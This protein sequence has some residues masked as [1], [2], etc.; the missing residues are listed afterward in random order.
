MTISIN[1]TNGPVQTISTTISTPSLKQGGL[2]PY[3]R[4]GDQEGKQ[5][6]TLH[7]I[8][9]PIP[10]DATTVSPIYYLKSE[11][12]NRQDNLSNPYAIQQSHPIATELQNNAEADNR[13]LYPVIAESDSGDDGIKLSKIA[14]GLCRFAGKYLDLTISEL[15][16]WYSGNRSIHIHTGEL[17]TSKGW[18]RLQELTKEFNQSN[19]SDV[20]IDTG[21]YSRK[22][23][24]RIPGVK[25]EKTRGRKVEI[26][27]TWSHNKIFKQSQASHRTVPRTYRDMLTE[28][29]PQSVGE[30]RVNQDIEQPNS[31]SET[32]TDKVLSSR[33]RYTG[34]LARAYD[35]PPISPYANADS[36]G[37]HS[38]TIVHVLDKPFERDGHN[39]VPCLVYGAIGGGGD[40]RVFGEDEFYVRRPVKLSAH[41]I[42]KWDYEFSDRVVILG[43]KSRRSRI[44]T[45]NR[46][47]AT[48]LKH[49]LQDK[50]RKSAIN[51]LNERGYET[52]KTGMNGSLQNQPSEDSARNTEAARLKR[53]IEQEGLG[54]VENEYKTI[55]R[56][57]CRLLRIGGWDEAWTWI[58]EVYGDNFDP[59]QTH[60][61]L[62]KIVRS[63][64]EYDESI[65]PPS[66]TT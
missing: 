61:K 20:E 17:V 10:D 11:E 49:I 16:L 60:Q 54:A 41:D 19:S 37:L 14:N 28:V 3:V 65:I 40:Y 53:Q 2:I 59:E 23:Q 55:L 46:H 47:E 8:D 57:S 39:Y 13:V 7:S 66:P 9:E 33:D 35:G 30:L 27:Q 29:V 12:I 4:Y 42:K 48:I 31:S 21:L 25:H 44:H 26:D 22:R 1:T 56:I 62:A 58:E 52:G 43:G 6:P 45:I 50:G 24:F 63:Y 32:N 5:K 36:D 38:V 34:R 51:Y 64:P 15:T 18:E